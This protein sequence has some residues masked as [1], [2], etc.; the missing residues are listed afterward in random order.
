MLFQPLQKREK[1]FSRF[2]KVE[3]K[4]E[5]IHANFNDINKKV[6]CVRN[7]SERLWKLVE[8]YELRN[9]TNVEIVQPVK[10]VFKGDRMF[11]FI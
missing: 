11:R 8:R 3:Q 5:S 1:T 10:R 6:W 4:G 9:V 2:Y 7:K